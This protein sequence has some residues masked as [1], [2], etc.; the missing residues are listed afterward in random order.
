MIHASGVNPNLADFKIHRSGSLELNSS[1]QIVKR[2]RKKRGRHLTFQ[3][4]LETTVRPVEAENANLVFVVI[5]RNKEGKALNVVPMHVR[6][7]QAQI[8]RSGTE[9]FLEGETEFTNSRA[10]IQHD[11]LTI[12]PN[13]DATGVAAISH[14]SQAWNWNRAAN[15]PNFQARGRSRCGQKNKLGGSVSRSHGKTRVFAGQN[16]AD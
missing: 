16:Q 6:N 14:R 13:L 7:Q 4:F 5:G 11:Q 12:G 3:D 8:D 9:L 2:D 1:G 10:C 15:A